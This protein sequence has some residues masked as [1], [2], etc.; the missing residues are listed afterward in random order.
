M[1]KLRD[2]RAAAGLKK[3]EDQIGHE[4]GLGGRS[5]DSPGD[6]GLWARLQG[7]AEGAEDPWRNPREAPKKGRNVP[8]DQR[9]DRGPEKRW[10]EEGSGR[11]R[12]SIRFSKHLLCVHWARPDAKSWGNRQ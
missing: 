6:L 4:A 7:E 8:P 2:R 10:E 3:G 12:V 1:D 9:K 11:S 5:K